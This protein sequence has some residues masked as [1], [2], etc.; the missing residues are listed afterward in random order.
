MVLATAADEAVVVVPGTRVSA[1]RASRN[2]IA[3]A[4]VVRLQDSGSAPPGLPRRPA[5]RAAAADTTA[6]GAVGVTAASY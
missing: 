3:V 4:A 6:T 5:H 1:D 2:K